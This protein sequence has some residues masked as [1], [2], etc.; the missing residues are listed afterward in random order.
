LY[1]DFLEPGVGTDTYRYGG[2]YDETSPDRERF[3]WY[4][5]THD[6]HN[7]DD[8]SYHQHL[9]FGVVDL[10]CYYPDDIHDHRYELQGR[11]HGDAKPYFYRRYDLQRGP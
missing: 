11:V 2:V 9:L 5:D 8:M 1:K 6:V 3:A 7:G 4:R 10:V